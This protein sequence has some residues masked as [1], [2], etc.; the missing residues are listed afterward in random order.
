M[1]RATVNRV[2]QHPAVKPALALAC[3]LP[4]AG[5]VAGALG[6]GAGLGVNPAE[7]V[8]R[9]TGDWTLHLLAATLAITPLRRFSGWSAPARWRRM[10]G[11]FT[12]FYAVLHF[13]AY[14]WLDM[15][16]DAAAVARDLGR[17]PFALVGFAAFVLLVPLAATSFD[18]VIRALGAAR[19]RRLHRAVYVVA[20]LG[21]VHLAWMVAPK[22]RHADLLVHAVP[23]VA[24]LAVRR[25]GARPAFLG[26]G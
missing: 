4:L 9:G 14:A 7:T 24:L 5:W 15:G 12:F 26:R 20:V 2:L 21:L 19:W 8:L 11:L 17:R 13:L 6:L 23:I 16:L 22:Q 10:L 25:I 18:R 1:D 3:L